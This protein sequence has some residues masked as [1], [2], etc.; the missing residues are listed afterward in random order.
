[1]V[2]EESRRGAALPCADAASARVVHRTRERLRLR[3]ASRRH[4]LPFFLALYEDLRNQPEIAE[5]SIN[6]AT[7]SVLLWFDPNDGAS[8]ESALTRSGRLALVSHADA[9]Q[10]AGTERHRFHVTLND[11]RILLFLIML[12]ISI[13]QIVKGQLL[14]PALTLSLYLAD[15]LAGIRMEHTAAEVPAA[16]DDAA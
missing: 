9:G 4:D 6:P 5:I 3:V 10:P 15:L 14:A 8:I 16:S 7:A 2:A 13:Q 12:G 1:M 11:M